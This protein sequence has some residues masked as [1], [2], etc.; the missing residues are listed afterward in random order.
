[1]DIEGFE[2]EVLEDLADS[3]K[4][5][6]ISSII[7]EYHPTLAPKTHQAMLNLLEANNFEVKNTSSIH[8]LGTELI[9]HAYRRKAE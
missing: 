8:N 2:V 9:T 6:L 7:F 1:M 3:H 5:K 4:L